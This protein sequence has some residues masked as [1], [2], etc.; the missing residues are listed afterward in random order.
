MQLPKIPSAPL[1]SLV[2]GYSATS[3]FR[4][5]GFIGDSLLS[6]EIELVKP[7]GSHSYHDFYEYSWG[8]YIARKNGQKAYIFARGGMSARTYMQ[9]FADEIGAWEKAKACQAYVIALGANDLSSSQNQKVG[10]LKDV[11]SS[12]WRNNKESFLGYYAQIVARLKSDVQ[13]DAKFFFVSMPRSGNDYDELVAKPHCEALYALADHFQNSYVMSTDQPKIYC[14]TRH[15][16]QSV[17]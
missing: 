13:S 9:S 4:T 7:D 2:S 5:I 17:L 12:N 10:T 8:N 14:A 6:G 11:D 3:I 1:E 15:F 16:R